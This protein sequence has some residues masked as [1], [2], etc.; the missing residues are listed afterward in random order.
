VYARSRWR[1]VRSLFQCGKH[2]TCPA[3]LGTE[4]S[5][6]DGRGW[7]RSDAL[8]RRALGDVSGPVDGAGDEVSALNREGVRYALA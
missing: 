2:V 5:G 1:G 6:P 8:R 3:E 4:L 7:M